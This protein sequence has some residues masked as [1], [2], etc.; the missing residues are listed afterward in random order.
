MSFS[1]KNSSSQLTILVEEKDSMRQNVL[2][3]D[4]RKIVCGG[5][6]G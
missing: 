6:D 1:N 4:F 5:T 3:M 2:E